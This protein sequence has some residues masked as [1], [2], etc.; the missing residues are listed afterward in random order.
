VVTE[1]FEAAAEALT[2][3]VPGAEML[4]DEA[5]VA[6]VPRAE[7]PGAEV[8]AASVASTANEYDVLGTRPVTANE[9]VVAVPIRT[10]FMR[11]M[12]LTVQ[13][14][15][16]ATDIQLRK[17]PLPTVP[18]AISPVGAPGTFEQLAACAP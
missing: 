13:L 4:G 9:L 15:G 7:V 14:A 18:L 11:T 16:G 2:V 12:Y 8:P 10:P 17:V 1:T 5:P 6:E 3:E